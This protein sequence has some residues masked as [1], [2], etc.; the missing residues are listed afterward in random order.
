MPAVGGHLVPSAATSSQSLGSSTSYKNEYSDVRVFDFPFAKELHLVPYAQ[1]ESDQMDYVRLR[2]CNMSVIQLYLL[3]FVVTLF[4]I[5][6]LNK[7]KKK[8]EE[9]KKLKYSRISKA[10]QSSQI[11]GEKI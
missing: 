1:L 11:I 7:L 4:R 6:Q 8:D 10:D 9:E 3:F 5:K 2:D